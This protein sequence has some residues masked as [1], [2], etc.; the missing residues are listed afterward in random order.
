MVLRSWGALAEQAHRSPLVTSKTSFT[1]DLKSLSCPWRDIKLKFQSTWQETSS[2]EHDIFLE[3]QHV[4]SLRSLPHPLH[5]LLGTVHKN[6][7][8]NKAARATSRGSRGVYFFQQHWACIC[9]CCLFLS[10]RPGHVSVQVMSTLCGGSSTF[11]PCPR[12]WHTHTHTAFT[13]LECLWV[14]ACRGLDLFP[15][16]LPP[17]R[18]HRGHNSE[19]VAPPGRE[20]ACF[21]S[22]AN[23]THTGAIQPGLLSKGL[24]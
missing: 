20:Q 1:S 3:S 16:G 8:Q 22:R 24:C 5:S 21:T 15:R 17:Q 23:V 2:H 14:R 10:Q 12:P 9:T 18:T 6:M 19:S 7:R 11:L 4:F 13:V